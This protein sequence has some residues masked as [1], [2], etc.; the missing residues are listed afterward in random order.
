[1]PVDPLVL[2]SMIFTLL[3]ILVIGGLIL[4]FPVVRRL[5]SAVDVWIETHREEGVPA[6]EAARLEAEVRDLAGRLDALER[7]MEVLSERQDFAEALVE[8]ERS[9]GRP[10]AGERPSGGPPM[11][12]QG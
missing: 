2:T 11:Q 6:A 9:S 5:G 1:M 4:A 8:G 7:R 10:G 12:G 3:V